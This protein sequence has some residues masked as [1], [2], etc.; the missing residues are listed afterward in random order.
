MSVGLA[1]FVIMLV[2]AGYSY[3]HSKTPDLNEEVLMSRTTR[4]AGQILE[5]RLSEGIEILYPK[6]VGTDNRL[7]FVDRDSREVSL[8]LQE[9]SGKATKCLRSLRNGM[10]EAP[11][12]RPVYIDDVEDVSFTTL[13]PAQVMIKIKFSRLEDVNFNKRS[14]PGSVFVI[15]LKN[16]NTKF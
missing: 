5:K 12:L 1:S 11:P 4:V 9:V 2:V 13:S 16:A 8:E 10:P 7:T 14:Y 6:A 3:F 15:G